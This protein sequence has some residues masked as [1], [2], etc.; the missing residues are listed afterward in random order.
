MQ[1]ILLENLA[2]TRNL[3]VGTIKSCWHSGEMSIHSRIKER[4]I[5]LGYSS[6]EAFAKAVEVTWQTVQQWEKEG[7]T[8]PNRNR[9]GKVAKALETTPEWLLYGSGNGE[10]PE[11]LKGPRVVRLAARQ[12]PPWC[13]PEAF[14]LLD[15]YYTCDADGR[16]QILAYARGLAAAMAAN[17][18]SNNG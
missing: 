3:C 6:Q 8:A 17:A 2:C 16:A 5:A 13:A 1:A 11:I 7:G 9:I 15:S 10:P 4:R 18:S 14:E 12:A